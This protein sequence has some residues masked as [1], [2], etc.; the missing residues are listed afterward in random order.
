MRT[1]LRDGRPPRPGVATPAATP[2]RAHPADITLA[3]PPDPG[4]R[5]CVCDLKEKVCARVAAVPG[6][7]Q[8]RLGDP[9]STSNVPACEGASSLSTSIRNQL[10]GTVTGVATG[11]AMAGIRLNVEGGVRA[12]A[13]TKRR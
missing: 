12:A 1:H 11:G 6:W 4:R 9:A 8:F 13:I 5:P 2:S 3:V 7:L 10:P